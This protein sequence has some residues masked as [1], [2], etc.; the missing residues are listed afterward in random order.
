MVH[1]FLKV[2]GAW[3]LFCVSARTNKNIIII[4]CLEVSGQKEVSC[5]GHRAQAMT[6][7]AVLGEVVVMGLAPPI[8]SLGSQQSVV[9][10][11]VNGHRLTWCDGLVVGSVCRCARVLVTQFFHVQYCVHQQ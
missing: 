7:R 8:P 11:S 1:T 10:E 3:L 6:L 5:D 9:W 4:K 2:Y